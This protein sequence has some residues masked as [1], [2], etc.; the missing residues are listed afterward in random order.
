MSA[1][2]ITKTGSIS[3]GFCGSWTD[4]VIIIEGLTDSVVI[5]EVVAYVCSGFKLIFL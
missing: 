3:G 4:S 5:I 2:N 1:A